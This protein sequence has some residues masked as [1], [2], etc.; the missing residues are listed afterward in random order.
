[1]AAKTLAQKLANNSMRMPN[2]CVWYTGTLD[3]DG[4]GQIQHCRGGVIRRFKAH[5]AAYEVAFG[6]VPK[7]L[8]VCHHCDVPRCINSDHLFAGTPKENVIDMISKGRQADTSGENS[9]R[10]ILDWQKVEEIR[11]S[12]EA[13]AALARRFGVHYMVVYNV[14]KGITWSKP[15]QS[16]RSA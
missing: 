7:G 12:P 4:Y 2:G 1:M 14:R 8:F 15:A 9:S 13:T 16:E 5:R 11:K 3:A 6:D 10:R